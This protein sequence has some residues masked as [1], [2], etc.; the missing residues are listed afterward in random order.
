MLITTNMSVKNIASA[1]GFEDF[2][3]FN[4]IFKK[5]MGI[6]PQQYREKISS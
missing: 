1:L 2:S 3:Y 5:I 6:T 4:R